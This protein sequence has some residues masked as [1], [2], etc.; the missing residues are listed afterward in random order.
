MFVLL[1]WI[2]SFVAISC[3]FCQNQAS[4]VIHK[5]LGTKEQ[6][7]SLLFSQQVVCIQSHL[8]VGR[9]DYVCVDLI[10]PGLLVDQIIIFKEITHLLNKKT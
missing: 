1:I 2:N 3:V 8:P 5:T 10:H 4:Q 7:F 9:R 6:D